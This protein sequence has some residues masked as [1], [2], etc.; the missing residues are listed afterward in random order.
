[1]STVRNTE[2]PDDVQ[3]KLRS[4][5]DP[6][7]RCLDAMNDLGSYASDTG[8]SI[9]HRLNEIEADLV[10]LTAEVK[11]DIRQPHVDRIL[12]EREADER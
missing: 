12:Q 1:M 6:L 7:R 5:N 2:L 10:N 4:I 8:Y 3:A 9:R 11:D